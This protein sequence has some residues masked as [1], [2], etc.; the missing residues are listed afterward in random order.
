MKHKNELLAT[1]QNN[2]ID[3][4]L[5]FETHFTHSSH[6]NSPGFQTFK[7]N[8]PDGTAHAGAAIIVRSSLLFHPLPP[9]QTNRIQSCGIAITLNYIPIYIYAVYCPPRHTISINQLNDFDT[10]GDKFIIGG[11]IN[12]KNTQWGCRVYNPRGN[13]LKTLANFQNFKIHASPSPT[14][15]PTSPRKKPD[16]LDIFITKIPNS[17]NSLIKNLDDLCSDHSSV[18][19]TIDKTPLF[20]PKKPS[21][22]QGCMDWEK[23]KLTLENKTNP[24]ISLKSTDDID[25]AVNLLTKSIQESA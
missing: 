24:K 16:I 15:W 6:F 17:L 18:Q 12:A 20:K 7:T 21:H 22:N 1:L 9:Y 11:D 5:I 4:A 10:L 25:E 14:Y 2:R 23:F 19:L 3:I 8:H 13:T